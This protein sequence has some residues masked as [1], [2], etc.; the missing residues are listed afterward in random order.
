L[1]AF[2]ELWEIPGIL[3]ENGYLEEFDAEEIYF[4][5]PPLLSH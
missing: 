2:D 5:L 3:E 1:P 4:D